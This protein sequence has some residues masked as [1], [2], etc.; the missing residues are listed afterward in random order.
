ML[1]Y[2]LR[3]LLFAIP[4]LIAIALVIFLL[5]EL[6]PGD[7]VAQLP[8]S[9]PDEVR[10]AMRAALG[11]GEAAHIR[12]GKWLWQMLLVEPMVIWDQ[13]FGTSLTEEMQRILSWQTR[14]PVMAL[15]WQH[16]PQTLWVVGLAYVLGCLIALPIGTYAAYRQYG[17]FDQ[18]S[19]LL[20]MVGYALPSFFSGVLLML[21]FSVHLGWFPMVY[22]TGHQIRDWDSLLVQLRQSALPVMV[23]TLQTTAQISRYLRA[24]MLDNL[25]QDY[26]RTARAKGLREQTVVMSHALRNALIPVVT[27]IALG[28]PSIFGG[29]IIVE[30]L[31][32]VNG[33]GQLLLTSIRANDVPTVQTIAFLLAVLIVL[34][35]ILADLLYALLDPRIRYD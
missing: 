21:L 33:I 22:D 26:M 28:L 30:N 8:L 24:A 19:G 5:L 29:A 15:I 2:T 14:A 9:I 11:L 18:V 16:L 32:G 6:A 35:N 13:V 7:P 25:D 4:T 27:L 10:A 31:F 12:F 17:L 34:A 3:R 20:T 1:R 23:L